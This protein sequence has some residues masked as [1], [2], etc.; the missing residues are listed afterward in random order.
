MLRLTRHARLLSRDVGRSYVAWQDPHM[1]IYVVRATG[2]RLDSSV[3]GV[4]GPAGPRAGHINIQL[5]GALLSRRWDLEQTITER[6]LAVD[7]RIYWNERWIGPVFRVLVIEWDAE[8]GPVPSAFSQGIVSTLDH[9]RLSA[10]ADVLERSREAHL[11]A[12]ALEEL[13]ALLAANGVRLHGLEALRRSVSSERDAV[14][15]RWL[16]ALRSALHT[17][18]S[19][20]DAVQST[21]R[22][23]RQLRRDVAALCERLGLAAD[24]LRALLV[25]ERVVSA[26][27]LLSARGA[28]VTEVARSVGFGTARALGL[29]L[30]RAGLPS[31]SALTASGRDD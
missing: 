7:P 13:D 14:T 8:Y 3:L 16:S 18:P 29:A 19:W 31:A 22:S 11:A 9:Q 30:E 20:I 2:L 5:D 24:G 1:R 23:E 6:S 28:S 12:A 4:L 25:R 21:G 10:I 26:A 27:L 17:Q 15:A